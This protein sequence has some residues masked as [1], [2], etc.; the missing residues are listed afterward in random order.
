MLPHAAGNKHMLDGMNWIRG[1]G[2]SISGQIKH[3]KFKLDALVQ[4]LATASTLVGEIFMKSSRKPCRINFRGFEF[5]GNM[6]I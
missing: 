3:W 6:I 2:K 5:C 4:F 1:N